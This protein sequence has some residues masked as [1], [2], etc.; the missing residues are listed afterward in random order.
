MSRAPWVFVC[1]LLVSL[2]L[3]G[4]TLSLATNLPAWRTAPRV[5]L[6]KRPNEVPTYACDPDGVRLSILK[7]RGKFFGGCRT[8][9]WDERRV[10]IE[11]DFDR[12]EARPFAE[13]PDGPHI[14][15]LVGVFPGPADEV[16][17]AV[18]FYFDDGIAAGVV[19]PRGWVKHL[20]RLPGAEKH[21]LLGGAW[22]DGRLELVIDPAPGMAP[23]K[24]PRV[25][26]LEQDGIA[27]RDLLPAGPLVC[28]GVDDCHRLDA[29][30]HRSSGW[31]YLVLGR[32][33]RD[34]PHAYWV[35]PSGNKAPGDWPRG[36]FNDMPRRHVDESVAG[37]AWP[38]DEPWA[39][40]A[41]GSLRPIEA[42]AFDWS[43]DFRPAP[44]LIE[45]GE[46]RRVSAWYQ[47]SSQRRAR[48]L[49]GR[50]LVTVSPKGPERP[51]VSVT[52]FDA[53]SPNPVA[54]SPER[55]CGGFGE[56][57]LLA[58]DSG[59][60]VLVSRGG[61]FV[62]LDENLQRTDPLSLW[63]HLEYG[64]S[65]PIG[66]SG[67]TYLWMLAWVVAGL[68]ITLLLATWRWL[69]KGKQGGARGWLLKASLGAAVHIAS[70][71]LMLAPLERLLT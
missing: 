54:Y 50:W 29:A 67:F 37:S 23:T 68:P 2:V 4:R 43:I 28:A 16:G 46:L 38:V 63:E 47:R 14:E 5:L 10:L 32:S 33:E 17:L 61:C 35:D 13:A 27:Q 59:G 9:D 8:P 34:E 51:L 7:W 44:L 65:A 58:R 60:Y 42:P 26:R 41:D 70:S 69:A 62:S 64:G 3:S 1:C 18:H 24:P 40:N 66:T 21:S 39:L 48:Q 36:W 55:S 45:G 57:H 6:W 49:N 71:A 19:G 11:L 22:V 30:L 52:E 25:L 31:S 12:G 53:T 56:A 15:A 20:Q